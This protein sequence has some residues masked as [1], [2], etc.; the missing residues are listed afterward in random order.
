MKCP[1]H[2]TINMRKADWTP[3]D[4]IDPLASR[5]ACPECLEYWYK[6]PKTHLQHWDD[7]IK[8]ID[9]IGEL[10]AID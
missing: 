6:M 3:P 4:G 10:T 9:F 8:Q 2:T 5:H 7:F 1:F